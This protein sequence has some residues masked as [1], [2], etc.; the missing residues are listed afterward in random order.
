MPYIESPFKKPEVWQNTA[1]CLFLDSDEAT[2]EELSFIARVKKYHELKTAEPDS[3]PYEF[4]VNEP[5]IPYE[6]ELTIPKK[7]QHV[8]LEKI[9]KAQNRV[10]ELLAVLKKVHP[11]SALYYGLSATEVVK[12]LYLE[13]IPK[14]FGSDIE[15]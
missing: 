9:S 5:L 3:N 10:D 7:F 12:K 14:Y 8:D 4:R 2:K 11:W 1:D 6:T 13:W 15:I